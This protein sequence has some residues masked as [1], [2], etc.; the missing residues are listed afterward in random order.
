MFQKNPSKN[1][2]TGFIGFVAKN[3]GTLAGGMRGRFP[4]FPGG[5]AGP[6]NAGGPNRGAAR[7]AAADSDEEE[8]IK[9]EMRDRLQYLFSDRL[10]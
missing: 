7:S 4:G 5:V 1:Y 3:D 2:I 9:A 8:D 6:A 10:H